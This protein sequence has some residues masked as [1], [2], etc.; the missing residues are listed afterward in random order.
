MK[1]VRFELNAESWIELH[2]AAC[3]TVSQQFRARWS[4]R[5]LLLLSDAKEPF[6]PIANELRCTTKP[7][8]QP[9]FLPVFIA[10]LH[11]LKRN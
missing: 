6:E 5:L 7:T 10:N 9:L 8:E 1:H 3:R 4:L 2:D 11:K